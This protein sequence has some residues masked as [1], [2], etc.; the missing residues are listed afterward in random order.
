M[1]SRPRAG[2]LSRLRRPEPAPFVEFYTNHYSRL[3]SIAHGRLGVLQDAEDATAETFRIAWTYYGAGN[4]L[5][6]PWAYQVL[7]NVIGN[8][9]RY[10]KRQSVVD[11][12]A[13]LSDLELAV[14]QS[15]DDDGITIRLAIREL[16]DADR[17][18]L[19]LAYWEDISGEDIAEILGCSQA[20]V[21]T[22]LSRARKNL[23][24]ILQEDF[25]LVKEES[26]GRD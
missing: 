3:L 14:T 15:P 22:R 20:A 7:R 8:Q 18:I 16:S 23:K 26:N 6:L 10:L 24:P 17:Q 19:E 4:E 25:S 12:G 21:R 1:T 9:Y 11:T 5:T 13:E 2:P